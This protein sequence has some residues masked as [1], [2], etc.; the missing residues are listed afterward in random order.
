VTKI[1]D[2]PAFQ[3]G[4]AATVCRTIL[5]LLCFS[6]WALPAQVGIQFE[7]ASLAEALQKAKRES[8]FV[9]VDGYTSWCGP[10]KMMSGKVFPDPRV[11]MF[12]NTNFVN[13]KVDME[14]D[15]GPVLAARYDIRVYPTLLYLDADGK[16]VHRVAGYLNVEEFLETSRIALDPD[17]NLMALE[18][19]YR[20][21][22]RSPDFLLALLHAKSAAGDPDTGKIAAEYLRKQDDL[23]SPAN[24]KIILQDVDDPFS[25]PFKYF[26]NNRKKFVEAFSEQEVSTRIEEVFENYLQKHPNMQLGEVQRVYGAVYPEQ[27]ARLASAYRIT[28]YRERSDHL[29]LAQAAVDHYTRYPC[30]DVDELNEIAWIFS[31]EVDDPDLLKHAVEWAEKSISIRE[32]NYNQETLANLYAKLG[33]KKLAIK[34]A[35]RSIELAGTVGEDAAQARALLDKLNKS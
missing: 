2:T 24:M 29:H 23:G 19:K 4:P 14:H 9:F 21:G 3:G 26:I 12:Y 1:F 25:E 8:K 6:P 30:S 33:K 31:K 27:G 17:R 7:H 35:R 10:C 18:R 20:E 11:G 5:I 15:E 28:Y 16:V 22:D 34:A 13:L 32:T